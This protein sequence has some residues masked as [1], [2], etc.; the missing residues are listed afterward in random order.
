MHGARCIEINIDYT[1]GSALYHDNFI[2]KAGEILPQLFPD[3]L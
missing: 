2:G 1:E 3:A